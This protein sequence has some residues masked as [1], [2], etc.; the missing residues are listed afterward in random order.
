MTEVTIYEVGPR[1][2]LQNES[3]PLPAKD[4]V[5]F[6]DILS[7]TGL[8][9]IESGAFVSPKWVPAMADSHIVMTDINRSNDISY[10]VLTP[11][12]K[13]L[14]DKKEAEGALA[15][16]VSLIDKVS[17][18]NIIHKNKASNLKSQVTKSVAAIA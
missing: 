2:G 18:R 14:E 6:I 3:V 12:I 11:N 4:K 7:R 9:F 8:K 1:D 13:G 17:K 16:V 10:P 15:K 5:S